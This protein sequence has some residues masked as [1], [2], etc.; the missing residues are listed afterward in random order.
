MIYFRNLILLFNC[1]LLSACSPLALVSAVGTTVNNA[2]YNAAERDLNNPQLSEKGQAFKVAITNMNLGVEYMRQGKYE[3]ALDKL[4]R[5][6]LAK[7]DFAPSYNVLGL[8]YQRLGD[9]DKAE[10]YFVKSI[11]LDPTDSSAYNNYGLLLCGNKRTEEAEVAFLNAANNP[12]YSTP[13]IALTNAGI[14]LLESK[15]EESLGYFKKALDKN[16]KFSHAL[17]QM[18]D[19]SYKNGDN[20][21][22]HQYLERYKKN[23]AQTPRSLWLGVRVYSELGYK[24]DVSS[25]IL[26]LKNKFPD[27]KETAAMK[28]WDF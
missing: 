11:K 7:P 5:S 10:A 25:Y 14:C 3:D 24:D 16:E 18:A 26:L 27:S 20:K 21:L 15:P 12:F 13:E 22:A 8:L 6:I 17:V 23:A 19:I 1:L 2:A 9:Q 28:E 4:N